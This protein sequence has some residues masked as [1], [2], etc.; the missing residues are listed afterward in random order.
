MTS[1]CSDMS[2]SL[3]LRIKEGDGRA[4]DEIY[5]TWKSQF[6]ALFRKSQGLLQV[7]AE[8][9]YHKACAVLLNNIE[10][11]RLKADSIENNQIKAYL[12]NTGRYILYN[13]RRKRQAPLTMDTDFIMRYGNSCDAE[14]EPYDEE[15]DDKLFIIRTAVRDMPNPCAQI[16]NL[17]IYKKKSH[18][19][20]A[21]I[22]NYASEDSVKTQR[23]R[24]MSKLKDKVKERFKAA[25]YEQ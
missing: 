8:D 18:K 11:G 14:D 3:I 24:C 25:G 16:L 10:T 23:H 6:M 21:Q 2:S 1:N 5:K 12:N 17:V 20:V 15:K 9:L 22:M 7:D 4:F 13:E 19:D